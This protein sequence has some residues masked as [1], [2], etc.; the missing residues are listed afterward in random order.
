ML[1]RAQHVLPITSEPI[2]DGAIL[3]RE[4]KISD[5]GEFSM[6]KLR[7][8]HEEIKDFGLAA[9]MPGLVNLHTHMETT[10]M[11]GMVHD[12][13]YSTW[14]MQLLEAS[15]KI[16][17]DDWYDSAIIGGLE[18]LSAGITTIADI[19]TTEAVC[20]ATQTLGIRSVLYREVG[21]MDKRRVNH[22]MKQAAAD[23]ARWQETTDPEITTIGIAPTA[24]YSCH[25]A[26]FQ[27]VSEFAVRN[28]NLPVALHLAGSIEEY[29]FIKYGSSALSIHRMDTK[30]GFVEVPPWLPTG[31]T[32]IRYAL[33]WGAFESD[34]V[35]AIH[36]V[37]VDDEDIEKMKEYDV[38]VATCPRCNAQ[39]GMGVAPLN[40]F[41][42]AGLRV[43]LGTDS[44]VA[45]DSIDVLLEARV[46]LLV[47][48]AV[49][50]KEFLDCET[51]LKMAT[52]N[53]ARALR[54]DEKIGSLEIGKYADIIALDLSGSHQ[55]PM[56]DPVSAVVNTCSGADVV[57]TM[58]NGKVLYENHKWGM[59]IDSVKIL[60]RVIDI[61]DKI[62]K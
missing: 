16:E 13:P 36:C 14:L 11:R 9:L 27:R 23:I 19:T 46:G 38:A 32:P 24:L 2:S 55:M 33:N 50:V 35:L 1:L 41:L 28:N 7:Y 5:I 48:R 40:D 44:P 57:M 18:S 37:H 59:E 29:N 4:G 47:Q 42:R 60:S 58:V 34:N 53:G 17:P 22:A 62:R 43:G 30:R 52:I 15:A 6:L 49:N 61:R 3:V 8:P 20:N 25:P 12:V 31:T 39:L 26:M 51:M 56:T 45:S 21:A 10:V 54:L